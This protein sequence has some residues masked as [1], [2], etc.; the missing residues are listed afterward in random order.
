[1]TIGCALGLPLSSYTDRSSFDN[2]LDNCDHI[3]VSWIPLS[4]SP[5]LADW[6]RSYGSYEHYFNQL[7]MLQTKSEALLRF[8]L[9][10]SVPLISIAKMPQEQSRHDFIASRHDLNLKALRQDFLSYH[11]NMMQQRAEQFGYIYKDVDYWDSLNLGEWDPP[12]GSGHI[13]DFKPYVFFDGR[14]RLSETQ[15]AEMLFAYF[16]AKTHA[17]PDTFNQVNGSITLGDIGPASIEARFYEQ[18]VRLINDNLTGSAVS[19]NGEWTWIDRL[20]SRLSSKIAYLGNFI[21]NNCSSDL[22]KQLEE[23][24]Y[25]MSLDLPTIQ[26]QGF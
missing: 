25:R 3:R 7:L 11:D 19:Y 14:L 21:N 23:N 15:L 1:M 4:D 26:Q 5:K 16:F 22:V 12:Q 20:D 13:E 2:K 18:T 24:L 9:R 8:V 6:T 17:C 10:Y